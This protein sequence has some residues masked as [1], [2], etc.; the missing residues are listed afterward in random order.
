MKRLSLFIIA[1]LAMLQV[2]AK[3]TNTQYTTLEEIENNLFVMTIEDN[4]NPST[5]YLGDANQNAGWKAVKELAGSS[6]YY[7]FK[8]EKKLTK[9]NTNYYAICCY[10]NNGNAYTGG[11]DG[12]N[13]LSPYSGGYYVGKCEADKYGGT[14]NDPDNNALWTIEVKD[15]KFS[16]TSASEGENFKGMKLGFNGNEEWT[17]YDENSFI[18]IVD[19]N[20][21]ALLTTIDALKGN[22]FVMSIGDKTLWAGDSG[23]PHN[24]GTVSINEAAASTRPYYFK[25]EAVTV[26]DN[27]Y[28]AIRCYNQD[29]TDFNSIDNQNGINPYWGGYFIGAW[30]NDIHGS[31]SHKYNGLWK[32]EVNSEGQFSFQSQSEYTDFNNKYLGLDNN[33]SETAIYW[34]CFRADAYSRASNGKGTFGTLCLPYNA[35]V[36]NATVYT[37]SGVD[38]N[39]NPTK[40]YILQQEDGALTAGKAYIF[41]ST[42]GTALAA[43]RTNGTTVSETYTEDALRGV[44]VETS[45]PDGAYIYVGGTDNAWKKVTSTYPKTV[46]ANKAYLDLSNIPTISQAE[47]VSYGAR[48]RAITIG[49]DGETTGIE[50]VEKA[51]LSDDA[52]YTLGGVHT[53]NAKGIRINKNKKYIVK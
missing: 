11:V 12:G 35:V 4:G 50:A 27:T 53:N 24:I 37:V 17:C 2:N 13:A 40:L 48:M 52:T 43:N 45:V 44:L 19:T 8:A 3:I 36:K 32:V 20:S 31:D 51:E 1:L 26:E 47:A 6:K 41:K 18:D 42:D 30:N 49:G 9:D 34:T 21:D 28:Y 15:G 29:K 33:K 39:T 22:Y 23:A 14:Q 5:Y 38:N 7:L 16:F 25:L 10:D 46:G